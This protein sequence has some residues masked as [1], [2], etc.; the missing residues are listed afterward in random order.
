M[1]DIL[2]ALVYLTT[3]LAAIVAGLCLVIN[4]R[5]WYS[6]LDR[7]LYHRKRPVD[8]FSWS[9]RSVR[10]HRISGAFLVL[11]AL[12]MLIAPL[13]NPSRSRN[14][15]RSQEIIQSQDYKNTRGPSRPI[16]PG[17]LIISTILFLVG[18][19]LIFKPGK[20]LRILAPTLTTSNMEHES[21]HLAV[22]VFGVVFSLVALITA[23]Q[24]LARLGR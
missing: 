21:K 11:V 17:I 8:S 14:G 22:R 7:L 24:Q 6:F 16:S 18:L 13:W 2:I 15:I 19:L 5:A 20:A 4:P 12:F 9:H 1:K 10:E 23:I 3:V